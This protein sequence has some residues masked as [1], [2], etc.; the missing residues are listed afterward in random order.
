M[1]GGAG[2]SPHAPRIYSTNPWWPGQPG[3]TPRRQANSSAWEGHGRAGR[4]KNPNPAWMRHENPSLE[5]SCCSGMR[6]QEG[7]HIALPHLGNSEGDQGSQL[8]SKEKE[9]WQ[10]RQGRSSLIPLGAFCRGNYSGEQ[11]K[12][13]PAP[14]QGG[15]GSNLAKESW[16][17]A[18][19][20]FSLP[21]HELGLVLDPWECWDGWNS[22]RGS[23]RALGDP[24]PIP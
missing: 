13:D 19:G 14:Q 21:S 9:P 24:N 2:P 17:E 6:G 20:G 4:A 18:Q 12:A 1:G 23:R 5:N 8:L 3:V 15:V 7:K 22:S 11:S 10:P 16:G